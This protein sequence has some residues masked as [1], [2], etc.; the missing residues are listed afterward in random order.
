MRAFLIRRLLLGILTVYGVATLTFILMRIVPGDPALIALADPSRGEAVPKAQLEAKRRELGLDKPL[1]QQYIT[2]LANSIRFNFG[3]SSWGGGD[4][5]DEYLRRLPLSLNM[6]ILAFIMTVLVGIPLGILSAIKQD[7]PLDYIARIIAISG[8]SMPSFWVAILIIVVL[9]RVF[10]WLPSLD[11]VPFWENPLRNLTQLFFP[12]FAVAF[13]FIG[14]VTRMTRS[15]LLEV[16]REDYIRTAWSKGLRERTII[17]RHA[18]R[19]ALLPVI[20]VLGL[21]FGFAI[22]GL[23]VVEAA[24]NLPGA[25]R[26]LFEATLRRDYNVIQASLFAI[27][28]FVTLAN[29]LVD[30]LYAWLNPRVRLE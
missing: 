12:S 13:G 10:S 18:L 24:F 9:L 7:T 4:V 5:V 22:G 8:L 16:L 2:W 3:K 19:N 17:L 21:Q 27:A 15:S 30:V 28:L 1:A 23:V 11:Y 29:L 20:T 25:G 26:F 14:V 6:A